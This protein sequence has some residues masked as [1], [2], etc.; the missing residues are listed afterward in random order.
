M[1]YVGQAGYY[2][3]PMLSRVQVIF[4][5]KQGVSNVGL[6]KML[7]SGIGGPALA[8]PSALLLVDLDSSPE[9]IKSIGSCLSVREHPPTHRNFSWFHHLCKRGI[10]KCEVLDIPGNF[11]SPSGANN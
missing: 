2:T 5:S 8:T 1:S 4:E 9:G 11:K 3:G 10:F 6:S 7:G